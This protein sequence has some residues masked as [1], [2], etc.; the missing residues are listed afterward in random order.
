M[1]QRFSKAGL[2]AANTKEVNLLA[3]WLRQAP[4]IGLQAAVLRAHATVMQSEHMGGAM[5]HDSSNAA[6]NW[7]ISVNGQVPSGNYRGVTP[8]GKRNDKRTQNGMT[9]EVM[10]VISSRLSEDSSKLDQAI[11]ARTGAS[12]VSLVNHISGYYAKNAHLDLAAKVQYWGQVA[13]SAAEMALRSWEKGGPGVD[14]SR[15]G[16]EFI[17]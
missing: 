6:Y 9:A 15:Y 10:A 13:E 4:R 11:W 14:W 16:K 2:T 8:V 3:G 1:V 5:M 17:D 12:H 7:R